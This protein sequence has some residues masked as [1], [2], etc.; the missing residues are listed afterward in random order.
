[1]PNQHRPS[2]ENREPPLGRNDVVIDP[3]LLYL[4]D[5][6]LWIKESRRRR[7]A[8]RFGLRTFLIGITLLSLLMALIVGPLFRH[9]SAHAREVEMV[10]RYDGLPLTAHIGWAPRSR[11]PRKSAIIVGSRAEIFDR[12]LSI[13]L[14]ENNWR[15]VRQ[16]DGSSKTLPLPHRLPV[17]LFAQLPEFE[18]LEIVSLHNSVLTNRALEDIGKSRVQLLEL[19]TCTFA[20]QED[21]PSDRF[22]HLNH[23]H[24]S[25]CELG[26]GSLFHHFDECPHLTRIELRRCDLP[27]QGWELLANV[28]S[29]QQLTLTELPLTEHG[30]KSLATLPQLRELDVSQAYILSSQ[31]PILATYPALETLNIEASAITVEV[32]MALTRREKQLTLEVPNQYQM[33]PRA[34]KIL[35]DHRIL[36]R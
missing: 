21:I 13:S 24:L 33:N 36:L 27:P 35:R 11:W 4:L 34:E 26:D 28:R 25:K 5:R 23:L 1:M 32:A 16:L 17:E 3:S 9:R 19:H 22:H 12:V 8:I 20:A 15:Q 18:Y 2:G 7:P 14:E 10:R 6:I 31:V 29:L 30:L